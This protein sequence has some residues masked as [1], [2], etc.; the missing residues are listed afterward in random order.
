MTTTARDLLF[1]SEAAG[2]KVLGN[3]SRAVLAD[4]PK[5]LSPDK[6]ITAVLA[7]LDFPL[8][9]LL[10]TAWEGYDQVRMA[11]AETRGTI[12]ARKQV[13]IG[14]HTVRST[15]HPKIECDLEGTRIFDLILDFELSLRF[16][17]VVVTVV[18]GEVV[19]IGPG[20]A[21][22]KASLKAKGVTLV[23]DRERRITFPEPV[24]SISRNWR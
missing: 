17:G 11:K 14:G 10:F 23:P 3:Q 12:K 16:D 4:L 6:I 9:D 13:R 5:V 8:S 1:P 20:S 19:S 2:K 22:A 7:V 24:L 21:L 15:Q 18:E